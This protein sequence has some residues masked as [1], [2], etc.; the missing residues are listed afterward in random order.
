M[1]EVLTAVLVVTVISGSLLWW[2]RKRVLM[3]RTMLTTLGR[4]VS[5]AEIREGKHPVGMCVQ[6]DFGRGREFWIVPKAGKIK[7]ENEI[8]AI[9]DGLIILPPPSIKDLKAFCHEN[10]VEMTV[11]VIRHR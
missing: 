9:Q 6:V 4:C 8:A 1:I 5:F 2:N 10:D 3:R 11:V 7:F